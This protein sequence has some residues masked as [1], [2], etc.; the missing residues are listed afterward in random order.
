MRTY[1]F[2][3]HDASEEALL[4]WLRHI[5][6]GHYGIGTRNPIDHPHTRE[7]RNMRYD[8]QAAIECVRERQG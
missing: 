8:A 2:S 3:R 7:E 6:A 5:D 4:M 1:G